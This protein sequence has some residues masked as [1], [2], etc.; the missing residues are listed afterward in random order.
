[1]LLQRF[2]AAFQKVLVTQLESIMK[3]QESGT[4]IRANYADLAFAKGLEG[5][6][7]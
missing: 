7:C 5:E 4:S 2:L 1:M 3:L 6:E